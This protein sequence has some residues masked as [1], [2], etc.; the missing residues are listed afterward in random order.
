MFPLGETIRGCRDGEMPNP[1]TARRYLNQK[2]LQHRGRKEEAN[3][4]T[5]RLLV[6]LFGSRIDEPC[7]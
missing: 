2:M 7:V 6:E 1:K 4:W 3:E 5:V